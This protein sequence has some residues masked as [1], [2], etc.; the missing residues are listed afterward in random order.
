MCARIRPRSTRCRQVSSGDS[1][2][3]FFRSGLT[4]AEDEGTL[5]R[6]TIK[7]SILLMVVMGIISLLFAYVFSGAVPVAR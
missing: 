2:G 6:F 3:V 4:G 7:H 1:G 5:F